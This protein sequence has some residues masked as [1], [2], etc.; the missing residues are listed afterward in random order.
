M[1]GGRVTGLEEAL[2]AAGFVGVERSGEVV[3]ARDGAEAPEF[4]VEGRV[5]A[6]RFPV[7]AGEAEREAWMRANPAGRLDISEGET[8]LVMVLPEGADLVAGLDVWRGLVQGC[9]RAAVGWRRRE[10]HLHGM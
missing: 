10:R 5:F 8:R 2:V 1:I 3:F 7:R 6:L 4:T 9:A